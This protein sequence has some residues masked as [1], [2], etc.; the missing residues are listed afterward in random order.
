MTQKNSTQFEV[1]I[2]VD[3]QQSYGFHVI[4]LSHA[5]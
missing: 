3:I 2:V 1:G 4:H 5:G